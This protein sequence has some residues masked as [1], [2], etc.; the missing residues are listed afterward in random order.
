[1][2]PE[3]FEVPRVLIDW[4]PKDPKKLAD[5]SD[6]LLPDPEELAEPPTDTPESPEYLVPDLEELI[7]PTEYAAAAP[8]E[9]ADEVLPDL[10]LPDVKD[11]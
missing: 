1:V 6:E 9:L 10:E 4:P 8:E 11:V 5:P 3:G 7:E 2:D